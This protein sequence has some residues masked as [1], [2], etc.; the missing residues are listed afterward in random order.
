MGLSSA[1][2]G[3]GGGLPRGS[4]QERRAAGAHARLVPDEPGQPEPRVPVQE[5]RLPGHRD[6][7]MR[8]ARHP[9]RRSAP[10]RT[11]GTRRGRGPLRDRA[12]P[13]R[14]ARA[15]RRTRRDAAA[16]GHGRTGL[17]PRLPLRAPGRDLR[18]R[19]RARSRGRLPRHLPSL[20]GRLR[21]GVSA[22][23]RADAARLRAPG[24]DAQAQGHPPERFQARARQPR[25]SARALRRRRDGPRDL[26][27]DRQRP[28]L[29]RTPPRGRDAGTARGVEEG[30]RAACARWCV[31]GRR[32]GAR[33][34]PRAGSDD[35]SRARGPGA[36]ARPSERAS[37]SRASPPRRPRT[38]W[39]SSRTGSPA[40][41][42][43]RWRI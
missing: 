4:G 2:R 39:A 23:V 27:A 28:A 43:A 13:G 37:T 36:G 6:R 42:R 38:S 29:P 17:V 32:N 33:R 34:P 41:T 15:H 7:A 22:R 12:Q 14:R 30:D 19:A 9:V 1:A 3:G 26:R 35:A 20:R 18:P 11:H 10:G 5:P 40:A 16:G 21:P 24:R 25:R 8:P 31:R